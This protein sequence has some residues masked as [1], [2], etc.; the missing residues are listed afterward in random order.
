MS[1]IDKAPNVKN[2]YPTSR[3]NESFNRT[4]PNLIKA[5]LKFISVESLI[6]KKNID[7]VF[8]CTKASQSIEYAEIFRKNVIVI[9]LSGIQIQYI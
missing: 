2:I 3:G 1:P 4:H 7:V 6:K 5:N 9:D 8:L